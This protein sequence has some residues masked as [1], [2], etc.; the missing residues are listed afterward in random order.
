MARPTGRGEKEFVVVEK[1]PV[2]F[3]FTGDVNAAVECR[4][5]G[6]C[7]WAKPWYA[8]HEHRISLGITLQPIRMC[9]VDCPTLKF[10]RQSQRHDRRVEDYSITGRAVRSQART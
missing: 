2:W 1:N 3:V 9:A 10:R 7:A 4:I 8:P 5:A 6:T